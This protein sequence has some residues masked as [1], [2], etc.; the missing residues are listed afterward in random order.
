MTGP[1]N[2]NPFKGVSGTENIE[3]IQDRRQ[4]LRFPEIDLN[5]IDLNMNQGQDQE[6]LID[7]DQMDMSFNKKPQM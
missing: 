1:I 5:P 3:Q 6:G 4:S 2:F 7:F